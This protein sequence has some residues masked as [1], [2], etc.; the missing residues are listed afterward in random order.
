[1]ALN[2]VCTGTELNVDAFFPQASQKHRHKVRI[3]SLKW[4]WAAVHDRDMGA[5]DRRHVGEFH[6]D[7]SAA[8]KDDARRQRIQFEKLVTDSEEALSGNAQRGRF[9]AH[10]DHDVSGFQN[11]SPYFKRVNT[12]ESGSAMKHHDPCLAETVLF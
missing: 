3:E 1:M 6:R 8:Y 5:G 9:H 4:P 11:F 7:V 2:S 10:G 12:C